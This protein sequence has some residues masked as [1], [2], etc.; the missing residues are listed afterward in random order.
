MAIAAKAVKP[1]IRIVGVE[2]A[3]YPSFVNAIDGED[4]PIGGAD[5]GRGHRGEDA[6]AS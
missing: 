2:A 1:D 4:R 6:S 3:L 5:A